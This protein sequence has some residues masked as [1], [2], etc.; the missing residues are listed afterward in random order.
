MGLNSFE[1]PALD[2][3]PLNEVLFHLGNSKVSVKETTDGCTWN[4]RANVIT[5]CLYAW[6]ALLAKATD[7]NP[8]PRSSPRLVSAWPN[9]PDRVALSPMRR[10]K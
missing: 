4:V 10:M 1:G 8:T 5:S 9:S 3:G 6:R 2:N 7:A